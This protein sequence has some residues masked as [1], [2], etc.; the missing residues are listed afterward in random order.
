M[1]FVACPGRAAAIKISQPQLT[2]PV[3]LSVAVA[4]DSVVG[5]DPK[6]LIHG[7]NGT[8]DIAA[9]EEATIVMDSAPPDVGTPGTPAVVAAPTRS[10]YQ[11]AQ[12]AMKLVLDVSF[13]TRRVGAV[14]VVSGCQW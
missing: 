3:L 13:A 7:F 4:A 5:L 1:V 2:N 11:T 9:S 6:A 14:A 8:P 10:M 12:L